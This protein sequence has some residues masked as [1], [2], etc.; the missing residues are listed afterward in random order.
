MAGEVRRLQELFLRAKSRSVDGAGHD[1]QL[2]HDLEHALIR[3]L[4][5]R[6]VGPTGSL[7]LGRASRLLP[8]APP[9]GVRCAVGLRSGQVLLS[10]G[11][12]VAW[13]ALDRATA[14]QTADAMRQKAE[15]IK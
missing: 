4:E 8:E 1:V 9:D 2:W 14:I 6:V 3:A 7:S 13:V 11:K 15:E 12:A 5:Q 10:F